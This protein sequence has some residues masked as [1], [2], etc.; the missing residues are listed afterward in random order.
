[1]PSSQRPAVPLPRLADF[2]RFV[3]RGWRA[4][5]AE[6]AQKEKLRTQA[7]AAKRGSGAAAAGA[8]AAAA[9]FEAAEA[10]GGKQQGEFIKRAAGLSLALHEM[11]DLH[12]QS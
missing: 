3:Q 12:A 4:Q 9:A 5:C 11:E 8:A 10:A 2:W 6:K 1:M 7:A